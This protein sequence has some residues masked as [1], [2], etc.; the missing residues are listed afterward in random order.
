MIS[1]DPTCGASVAS[2]DDMPLLKRRS[3]PQHPPSETRLRTVAQSPI[4]DLDGAMKRCGGDLGIIML[5][6]QI[7]QGVGA[8][9][10]CASGLGATY[11]CDAWLDSC[12]QWLAGLCGNLVSAFSYPEGPERRISLELAAEESSM[13]LLMGLEREGKET[14]A[15]LRNLDGSAARA[16][17]EL[18]ARIDLADRM[19]HAWE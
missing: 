9:E 18:V 19:L 15:V 4:S 2:S 6:R 10:R 11:V 3:S 1:R 14:V 7:E 13:R 5:L 8:V 12:E 16:A 17:S